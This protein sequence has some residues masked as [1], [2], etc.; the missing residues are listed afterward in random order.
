MKHILFIACLATMLV[1]CKTTTPEPEN[2][3]AATAQWDFFL[4]GSW[5]YEETSES[6]DN[7]SAYPKG[8]ESFNA[9]GSYS[10]YAIGSN[11]KK[12]ILK[13]T[14]R[15]DDKE[16]YTVWVTVTTIQTKEG[17]KEIEGKPEKYTIISLD[18]MNTLTYQIDNSVRVAEWKE[19]K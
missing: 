9:D 2:S 16:D 18:P 17:E 7:L 19:D 3:V 15:L 5:E 6:E 4:L 12:S 14:W 11:G 10:N 8:T 13:G 1:A